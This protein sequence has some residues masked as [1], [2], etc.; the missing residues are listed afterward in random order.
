[1]KVVEERLGLPAIIAAIVERQG[2]IDVTCY[3]DAMFPLLREGNISTFTRV[4][5]KELQPG[6]VCLYASAEGELLI[7]RIVDVEK[8]NHVSRYIFRSDTGGIRRT[9]IGFASI[10]GRLYAVHRDGRAVFAHG[11]QAR[12]L[13]SAAL[14]LPLWPKLAK[15]AANRRY[16]RNEVI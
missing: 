4:K 16:R 1:M 3:G 9:P 11:W 13:E 12:L 6:D 5:E 14:Q 2:E 10:I 7:E 8:T 15:F